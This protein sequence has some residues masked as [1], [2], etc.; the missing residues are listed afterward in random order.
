M[1][2]DSSVVIQ[3]ESVVQ[4]GRRGPRQIFAIFCDVKIYYAKLRK[5]EIK[6]QNGAKVF[7]IQI[8]VNKGQLV[9]QNLDQ[10]LEMCNEKAGNLKGKEGLVW[11]SDFDSFFV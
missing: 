3:P 6:G 5:K 9:F 10:V 8:G 7:R 4:S 11:F 1:K 2:N